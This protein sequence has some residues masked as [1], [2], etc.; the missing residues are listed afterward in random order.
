[1]LQFHLDPGRF[2]DCESESESGSGS[3]S[4]SGRQV[5]KLC[6]D[7]HEA[8]AEGQKEN[9]KVERRSSLYSELVYGR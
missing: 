3:G 6:E 1:M 4:G 2:K 5:A 8:K 9:G 7:E